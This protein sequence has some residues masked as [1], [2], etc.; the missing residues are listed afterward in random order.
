MAKAIV[1]VLDSLGIGATPDAAGFGDQGADTLGSIMAACERGEADNAQRQ[2]P[3]KIPN[4]AALG[5]LHAHA[6][7]TGQS[8]PDSSTTGAWGAA[9]ELSTGKDT[10]SGHWEMAGVPMRAEFGYFQ[11]RENSFPPELL[12]E[13]IRR[14][15]LPGVLGNCHASGTEIIERLGA[16]H[17]ASGQPIVYTSADSVFQIAAHETHFGLERLLKL[18]E[19]ARE[20]LMPFNIGRVIAR[21]FSGSAESGF[22][23]T[24]NRRDYSLPPPAPTVLERLVESGGEVL[25]VGKIADI[26]AQRGI[27]RL[28]KADGNAALFEATLKAMAEAGENSLVFSNF[29]DFDMLYGH[30]RDTAGY[31]QALEDFD[32]RLPDLLLRLAPEDL[33]ILSADHGCDPTF[34]GTDHTREH[35]PVLALGAGL[36]GG[37]LGIRD[38][39]ADI[40]QSLAEFFGLPAMADGESFLPLDPAIPAELKRLRAHAW[41]PWS[42]IQVAALVRAGNGRLYGGCNVETSHYKSVCAEAG[43]ISAMVADGQQQLQA[44]YILGPQGQAMTPCGD[45]RQR[46]AEFA[47]P[48]C[49]VHLIAEDGRRHASLRLEDLLPRAFKLNPV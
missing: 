1:L 41:A 49:R 45:C 44:V 21:P 15:D 20:L 29:V 39:F 14:A 19:L 10:P 34:P 30:R 37:S 42:K 3:L 26:F 8:P 9:R 25:A 7:A 13:L 24:G 28:Y 18:C 2:G 48:D 31:A 5:L 4:L 36:K 12:A 22:T 38:S 11:A 6:L 47:R 23:R 17:I 32:R 35:V 43:A 16:E 27:S 33:L 40:G 46:L